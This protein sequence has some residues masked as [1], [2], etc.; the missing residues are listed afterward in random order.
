M[1]GRIDV[2]SVFGEG[3]TF[4]V[5]LP[6]AGKT[7]AEPDRNFEAAV[8]TVAEIPRSPGPR[9]LLYIEDNLSNLRLVERILSRRPKVKLISAMQASIGLD[10]AR[11]HHPDLILLDLHLPDI[12]GDEVLRQLRADRRTAQIPV[13]VVSA[14]ATAGQI[15]RLRAAGA[16]EYLTKPIDVRRFLA[17]IDA[18]PFP[19]T[20]PNAVELP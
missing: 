13:V 6:L 3:T 19:P 14:D 18:T 1:E 15:E 9:T 16:N 10:L 20:Q 8:R 11:Q 17:V 5:E 7:I 12:P 4:T 2:E